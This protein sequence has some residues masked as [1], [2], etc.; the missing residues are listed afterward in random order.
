MTI[1]T[2]RDITKDYGS[3]SVLHGID[4]HINRGEFVSVM[5][6][7]GSGKSTLM[8][9]LSGLEPATSGSVKL[10]GH[11][12]TSA[13]ARELAELRL[14][15]V[16]F[17]FQEPH[18][19]RNLSLLDNIVLPSFLTA[20]SSRRELEA[21]GRDL[22]ERLGVGD[23]ADREVTEA[24]GGQLQRVGIAR[25]LINDPVVLFGDEPTGALDSA[26]SGQVMDILTDINRA[27]TTI[28]LVTH[29][30]QVAA[31]TDRVIH[32]IDGRVDTGHLVS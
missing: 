2:G 7:S 21:R 4:V 26:S 13:S 12:L 25:A 15:K 6:P 29:D 9:I 8:H 11:D 31:R 22:M 28:V 30:D 10:D 19:L 1:L 27:G 32:L 18:L 5:G 17:V 3:T 16:G 23:L 14:S 20:R 24:S